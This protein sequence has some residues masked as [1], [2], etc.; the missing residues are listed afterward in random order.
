[1]P[2]YYVPKEEFKIIMKDDA[3]QY[4]NMAKDEDYKF[5]I[6]LMW[7][8]GM[9]IQELVNL[10]IRS[11]TIENEERA[12]I[13]KFMAL[14]QRKKKKIGVPNFSFSDPFIEEI[15]IPYIGKAEGEGREYALKRRSKSSYQ[16]MLLAINKQIHGADKTRYLTFHQ[17]RHSRITQ[18]IK[19]GATTDELM[20]WTGRNTS[21]FSD[22]TIVQQTSKF[23]GKIE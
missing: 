17:F 15:I 8:T 7:L 9:R 11:V 3:M 16:K 10:T 14:K 23:R 5:S 1:M 19:K 18:L 13:V 6:A 12:V 20:S 21:D 2:T 22:Y 4:I